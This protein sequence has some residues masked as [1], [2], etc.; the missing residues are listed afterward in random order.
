MD[1]VKTF[2]LKIHN[3]EVEIDFDATTKSILLQN[4]GFDE[5]LIFFS[6]LDGSYNTEPYKIV[7]KS[8]HVLKLS[9]DKIKIKTEYASFIV[10]GVFEGG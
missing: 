7:G 2:N 4:L 10:S 1:I 8:N 3:T 9:T 5:I 6:R